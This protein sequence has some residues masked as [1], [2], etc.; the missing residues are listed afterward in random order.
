MAPG[1]ICLFT[2]RFAEV[3]QGREQ[4]QGEVRGFPRVL[5]AKRLDPGAGSLWLV[6]VVL[7][8][9]SGWPELPKLFSHETF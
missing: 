2:G 7:Q 3:Q 6:P 5:G 4:V 1:R 8:V 9:L